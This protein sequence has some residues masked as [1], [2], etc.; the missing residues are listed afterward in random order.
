M[1]IQVL[2]GNFGGKLRVALEQVPLGSLQLRE[3]PLSRIGWSGGGKRRSSSR[4]ARGS[5]RG[6]N[7]SRS[8]RSRG[9]GGSS[10]CGSRRG[11]GG[12]RFRGR[13]AG[14]G[15]ST[16]CARLARLGHPPLCREISEAICGSRVA[17]F[18]ILAGCSRGPPTLSKNRTRNDKESECKQHRSESASSAQAARAAPGRKDT[19][20]GSV[21]SFHLVSENRAGAQPEGRKAGRAGTLPNSAPRGSVGIVTTNA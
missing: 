5:S 1:H 13:C 10:A 14:R 6:S 21:L 20:G 9:G 17:L 3:R 12:V 18:Q 16:S 2:R 19:C 15:L 7:T 4:R 8:C 11:R